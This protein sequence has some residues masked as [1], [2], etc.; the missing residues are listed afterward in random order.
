[1]WLRDQC[2]IGILQI[3]V[4]FFI[5]MSKVFFNL[6]WTPAIL[7]VN[8][9]CHLQN[10]EKIC[11]YYLLYLSLSKSM[12]TSHLSYISIFMKWIYES[13][14][15]FFFNNVV[16]V[17]LDLSWVLISETPNRQLMLGL[18]DST[19]T[20]VVSEYKNIKFDDD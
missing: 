16:I 6:L 20:S 8:S 5:V 14:S 4:S 13:E 3:R 1:M 19:V 11:L 15:W 10:E 18:R 12:L 17:R 2:V 7:Q 9:I